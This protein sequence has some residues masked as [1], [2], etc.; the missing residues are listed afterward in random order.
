LDGKGPA[1]DEAL[2]SQ[3]QSGDRKRRRDVAA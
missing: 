1:P 2:S 3:H